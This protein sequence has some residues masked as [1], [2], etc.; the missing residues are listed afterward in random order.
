MKLK[1]LMI[2]KAIVCITLGIPAVIV[3]V[4]FYTLFGLALTPAGAFVA[5]EYGASLIGNFLLTWFARD[6]QDPKALR[7]ILLGMT[8]YNGIGFIATLIAT[9]SGLANFMGWGAAGIY[10]FFTVGFGYHLLKS[11]N[12]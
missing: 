4:L 10:L 2:I 3:P 7:A 9:L 6:V 8:F 12:P 5:Q 1:T 11:P